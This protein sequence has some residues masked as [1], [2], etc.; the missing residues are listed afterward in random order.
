MNAWTADTDDNT[1]GP[2]GRGSRAGVHRVRLFKSDAL[3]R[4]TRTS[5]S[6]VIVFWLTLSCAALGVGFG[7][8]R[9]DGWSVVGCIAGGAAAWTLVEYVLHRF[10]FHLDRWIPAAERLCFVIH[11]CH[12]A[13]PSDAGR[14]IMP[15]VAS[16][17]MM[18][19]VLAASAWMLGEAAGL[20]FFGAFSLSYL[21][22]DVTHYGCH[23]WRL[24]GPVGRYLKR[25]HLAHHFAD[26]AR[27]F[28][29]T[30]PLWDWLLGTKRGR[31]PGA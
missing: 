23:Q 28:G 18:A 22:Y 9:I 25:H 20:L 24:P 21:I 4:L 11:G 6:S 16:A 12:H 29:V 31:S 30:S 2:R 26:D 17:P 5:A 7:L 10:V 27:D 8:D 14:D 1:E 19:V 15:P 13:D 3:E